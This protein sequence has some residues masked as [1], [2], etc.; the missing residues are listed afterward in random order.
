[1]DDVDRRII[2]HLV[3]DGR[4]GYARIAADVGLSAPAVK[5]RVDRLVADGVVKGFTAVVDPDLMGWAVEAYVEVHCRGTITPEALGSAFARIP[6]IHAA[7]TVSG[8]ADAILRIV[9]RDVRDLERALERV[10]TEVDNVDHTDTAI[11][12]SR[13]I[14]RYTG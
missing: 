2:D 8:Q 10:R 13:L 11:V 14:D 5:R 7:A 9:A 3:R 4:A 1:M 6:E 12:L